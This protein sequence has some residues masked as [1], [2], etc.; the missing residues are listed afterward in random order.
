MSLIFKILLVALGHYI[1]FL[2]YPETG[3]YGNLYLVISILA[4]SGFIVIISANLRFIK[5]ISG[6]AG[7]LFNLAFFALM[8][9]AIAFTMPQRDRIPVL[10]KIQKG[11]FPD[12]TS[13]NTGLIKIRMTDKGTVNKEINGLRL[14]IQ[15]IL[16][17]IKK[18]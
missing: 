7:L 6:A 2:C 10:E 3:P 16:K 13:L 15:K 11:Q 14:R 5:F 4:W 17:N 18:D 1:M 8:L 12:R 9:A